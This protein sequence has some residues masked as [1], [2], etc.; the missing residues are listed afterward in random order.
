MSCSERVSGRLARIQTASSSPIRS[1]GTPNTCSPDQH[2]RPQFHGAYTAISVQHSLNI[3][4]QVASLQGN[5]C[6]FERTSGR[7]MLYIPI[8][9]QA[10]GMSQMRLTLTLVGESK[11]PLSIFRGYEKTVE[12]SAAV[13]YRSYQASFLHIS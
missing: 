9:V 6:R 1:S 8:T 11:N 4:L 3:G 10:I 2:C 12:R 5:A 13:F 7:F